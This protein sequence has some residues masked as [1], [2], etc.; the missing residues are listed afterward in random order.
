MAFFCTQSGAR[1]AAPGVSKA[2][3][4]IAGHDEV[5]EL[6]DGS[7]QV[8]GSADAKAASSVDKSPAK[9]GS[10]EK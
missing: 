6:P 3:D 1:I 7:L 4:P 5:I 2:I 9:P 10:K 8:V